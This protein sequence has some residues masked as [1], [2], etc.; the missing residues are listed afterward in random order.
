VG[1]TACLFKQASGG[2]RENAASTK[3]ESVSARHKR[4]NKRNDYYM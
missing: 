4:T 3:S 1:D 2:G